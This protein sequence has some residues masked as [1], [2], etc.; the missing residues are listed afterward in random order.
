MISLYSVICLGVPYICALCQLSWH[1]CCT[2]ICHGVPAVSSSGLVSFLFSVSSVAVSHLFSLSSVRVSSL[3]YVMVSCL[4]YHLSCS[5]S[6]SLCCLCSLCHLS[7]LSPLLSLMTCPSISSVLCAICPDVCMFSLLPFRCSHCFMSS[8]P[9]FHLFLISSI[10][11][12][13]VLSIIF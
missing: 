8:V 13:S 10:L 11:V 6:L 3:V 1:L 12:S 5:L 9:V 4:F 2:I 7:C